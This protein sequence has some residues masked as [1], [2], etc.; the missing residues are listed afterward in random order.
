MR[1]G[2][3]YEPSAGKGRGTRAEA[4]TWHQEVTFNVKLNWGRDASPRGHL[5]PALVHTNAD[6]SAYLAASS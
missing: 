1:K 2:G 6:L 5:L 4:D 3:A